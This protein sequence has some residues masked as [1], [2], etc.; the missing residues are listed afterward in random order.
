M[1]KIYRAA[2]DLNG[3]A[4]P[5]ATVQ[6]KDS[7][8]GANAPIYEDDE[9]TI[10]TN[11]LVCNASGIC[12]FKINDGKY[13]I[14]TTS[15]VYTGT[16]TQ[17][18]IFDSPDVV[19]LQN[20]DAATLSY[21]QLCFIFGN[22][23]VKKAKSNGTEAEASVECICLESALTNGSSGRFKING[24]VAGLSGTAG[25]I[26]YLSQTGTITTTPPTSGAGDTFSTIVGRFSKTNTLLL[27]STF[28]FG[29]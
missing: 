18:S 13:D 25:A 6:V 8:S 19:Y 10:K 20:V 12:S 2:V 27:K 1:I 28:P 17:L 4:L 5:G 23:T 22:G 15:G 3:N 21:G 26:G 24:A 9:V 16:E 11:P 29:L 7:S 14:V